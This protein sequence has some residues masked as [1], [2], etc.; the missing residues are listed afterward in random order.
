MLDASVITLTFAC[1][2]SALIKALVPAPLPSR[3]ETPP[4][5]A[6][7]AAPLKAL[8]KDSLMLPL[9]NTA[10]QSIPY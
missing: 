4:F 7:E 10:F 9:L 3:I 8:V 5:R 2:D 6:S 1:S